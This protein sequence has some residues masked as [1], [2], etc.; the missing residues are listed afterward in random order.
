MQNLS[1]LSSSRADDTHDPEQTDL[2]PLGDT[3]RAESMLQRQP[4]K[5]Q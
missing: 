2:R 1:S 5:L 4:A 3:V